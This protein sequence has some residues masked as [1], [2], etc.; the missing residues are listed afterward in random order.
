MRGDGERGKRAG[1]CGKEDKIR[2][3]RREKRAER[4]EEEG[5][6]V[7]QNDYKRKDLKHETIFYDARK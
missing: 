4:E 5:G 1:F 3:K 7:S 6:S 2:G